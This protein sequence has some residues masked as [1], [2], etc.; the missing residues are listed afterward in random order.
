[1]INQ[2]TTEEHSLRGVEQ[3][4]IRTVYIESMLKSSL[5]QNRQLLIISSLLI[6]LLMGVFN[7]NDLSR[8]A[9][10]AI[11][12]FAALCFITCVIATLF[13]F[14]KNTEYLRSIVEKNHTAALLRRVLDRISDISAM[15]FICGLILLLALVVAESKFIIEKEPRAKNAVIIQQFY[16][17]PQFRHHRYDGKDKYSKNSQE[18][19]SQGKYFQEKNSV[20]N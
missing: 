16:S 2:K 18:K 14:A 13:F 10:F 3:V 6:A 17:Q 7:T 15:S 1:M 12:L 4:E 5:E 19:Y 11:W 9:S 8:F 20:K